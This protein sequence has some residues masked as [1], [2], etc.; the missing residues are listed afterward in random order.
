MIADLI[1]DVPLGVLTKADT[2]LDGEE[3][4]WLNILEGRKHEIALGYFITKQPGP[5]D[6]LSHA[7]ARKAERN[8]FANHPTWSAC[9]SVVQGKMG[10]EQLG[11]RLSSL[12]SNLIDRT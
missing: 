8:F 3:P 2:V 7:D 11:V 12:L 4:E 9:S 5:K 10:T 6:Q 1:D